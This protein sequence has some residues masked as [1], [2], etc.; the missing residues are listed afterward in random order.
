MKHRHFRVGYDPD[1]MG[2]PIRLQC[3]GC[4]EPVTTMGPY[5]LG[6]LGCDPDRANTDTRLW[7]VELLGAMTIQG[8]LTVSDQDFG[9]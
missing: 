9:E 4:G 3:L 2:A 6:C 7:A 8:K 1:L 5:T